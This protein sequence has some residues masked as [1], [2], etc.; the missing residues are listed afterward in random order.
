M[1]PLL[2]RQELHAFISGCEHL[3]S[4]FLLRAEV[5]KEE[6]DIVEFYVSELQTLIKNKRLAAPNGRAASAVE[7]RDNQATTE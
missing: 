3:I 7:Q 6:R 4:A 2:P 5:P 1:A